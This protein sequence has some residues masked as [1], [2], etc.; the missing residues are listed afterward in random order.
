M[1]MTT[2]E[3]AANAS[4]LLHRSE[5]MAKYNQLLRIE[6]VSGRGAMDAIA[7]QDA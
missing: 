1:T 3:H 2:P 7:W 5:R 6:E 4:H